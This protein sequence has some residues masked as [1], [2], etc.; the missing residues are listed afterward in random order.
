MDIQIYED[1]KNCLSKY[2]SGLEQSYSAD[3]VEFEPSSPQYPL[4]KFVEVRNVPYEQHRGSLETVAN[5]GY[6]VDVYAKTKGSKTKADIARYLAKHCNDFL[7]MC[8]RL[9]QVSWNVVENDGVNGALYHIIIMYSA[10][11]F[12]QRRKIL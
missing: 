5:L 1:L 3:V 8:K 10:P 9:R 7:T 4:I 2:I 12:E 6:R 11:Y